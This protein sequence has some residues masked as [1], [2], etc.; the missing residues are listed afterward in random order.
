MDPSL[1]QHAVKSCLGLK[2]KL[3]EAW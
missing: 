1:S 3:Q 2:E